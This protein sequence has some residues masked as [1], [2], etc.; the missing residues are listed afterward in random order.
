[1]SGLRPD[2]R[3]NKLM[4]KILA[5]AGVRDANPNL[6]GADKY[7][8]NLSKL[9]YAALLP[10]LYSRSMTRQMVE[11]F[12]VDLPKLNR[13]VFAETNLARLGKV[14]DSLGADLK[15]DKFGDSEGISLRGFYLNDATMVS[16]PLIVVNT[17]N[18]PICVA[19]TFW[20][21]VGHHLTQKIF[22]HKSA[23]PRVNFESNYQDHL[24]DPEEFLA[25]LVM[26][27]AAYPR[28]YAE[29]IFGAH[30]TRKCSKAPALV[31]KARKHIH[32]ICGYNLEVSTRQGRSLHVLAGL[33]HAAK[34]RQAL[35]TEYGI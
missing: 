10:R 7:F 26:V 8:L 11:E 24:T 21:E 35:L 3:S 9:D 28:N 15:P 23:R 31:E 5:A 2:A 33:I 19:A 16:R 18:D 22:G 13:S 34:L 30:P 17:A 4:G 29:R 12:Q 6:E 27:L 14:A 1:M 32:S 20:H 25:D